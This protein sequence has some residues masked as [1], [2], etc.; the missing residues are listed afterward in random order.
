MVFTQARF[1]FVCNRFQL[2]LRRAGANHKKIRKRRDAAQI[3]HNDVL[4]LFVRGKFR[5][6]F[7]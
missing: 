5:A 2:R 6:G 3:Q 4:G 7:C 1:D